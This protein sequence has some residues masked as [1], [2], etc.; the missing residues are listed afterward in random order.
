MKDFDILLYG[1]DKN[2]MIIDNNSDL[3]IDIV[4]DDDIFDSDPYFRVFVGDSYNT[5]TTKAKISI[6]DPHYM[7]N[8]ILSDGD[9]KSLQ[10]M[11]DYKDSIGVW[12]SIVKEAGIEFMKANPGIK[13]DFMAILNNGIP[14]LKIGKGMVVL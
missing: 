14:R 2:L 13:K 5:S 1:K 8:D 12:D 11:I 7:N 9:V 3:K 4:R 10:H 6:T